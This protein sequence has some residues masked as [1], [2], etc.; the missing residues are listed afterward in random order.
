MLQGKPPMR[1]HLVAITIASLFPATALAA[2]TLDEIVSGPFDVAGTPAEIA[3]KGRNCMVKILKNDAVT[4]RDSSRSTVALGALLDKGDSNSITGGDVITVFDASAGLVAANSRHA[5]PGM[6]SVEYLRSTVTLEAREGRFR[7]VQTNIARASS[8]TGALENSGFQ[9]VYIQ[10][11]SGHKKVAA[12]LEQLAAKVAAC[13][14][15][16]AQNW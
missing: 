7:I 8:D 9:P 5:V 15:A 2:K 16:P 3:T 10:A 6:L 4:V 13:V 1:R 11:M 12:S 14:Q